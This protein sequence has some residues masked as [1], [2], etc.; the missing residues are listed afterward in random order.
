MPAGGGGAWSEYMRNC[1]ASIEMLIELTMMPVMMVM[2]K[3]MNMLL[4]LMLLTTMASMLTATNQEYV[5]AVTYWNHCETLV[6]GTAERERENGTGCQ[7]ECSGGD[8]TRTRNVNE[9]FLE[10][11]EWQTH[12]VDCHRPCMDL[13]LSR[14]GCKPEVAGGT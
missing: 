14:I 7:Y 11:G 1:T 2:V 13:S 5:N 6:D 8:A 10:G 9:V 4:F 3:K 12:T